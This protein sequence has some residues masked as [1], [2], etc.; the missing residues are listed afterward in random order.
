M[1]TIKKT[2]NSLGNHFV[3]EKNTQNFVIS[4][5]H[6]AEHKNARNSVSNSFTEKKITRNKA[7]E[8]TFGNLFQTIQGQGRTLG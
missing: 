5:H 8:K 2:P 1:H 3:E 6:S 7:K 4:L